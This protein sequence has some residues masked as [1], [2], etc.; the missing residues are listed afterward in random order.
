VFHAAA[1]AIAAPRGL[2]WTWQIEAD[3][4]TRFVVARVGEG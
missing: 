2:R 3:G 1:A 4:V